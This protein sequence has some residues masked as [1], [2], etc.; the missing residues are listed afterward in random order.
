MR[1]EGF[2]AGFRY[3][4]AV[5]AND[6]QCEFVRG[7]TTIFPD[8]S[9]YREDIALKTLAEARQNEEIGFID[10]PYIPGGR[11]D[12]FNPHTGIEKT[13]YGRDEHGD[14]RPRGSNRPEQQTV[15]DKYKNDH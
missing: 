15:Q 9:K 3:D 10:N 5:R 14:T 11:K 1:R 6:F 13:H 7:D 2:C 8:V 4:L 12:N